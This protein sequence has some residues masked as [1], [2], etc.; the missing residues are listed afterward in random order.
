M[1]E[2]RGSKCDL[3]QSGNTK[4]ML[5]SCSTIRIH[6][7]TWLHDA[8]YVISLLIAIIHIIINVA[9][10]QTKINNSISLVSSLLCNY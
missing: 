7:Y 9:Q 4:Y 6:Q 2:P 8:S 1:Q 10:L 3:G 5:N